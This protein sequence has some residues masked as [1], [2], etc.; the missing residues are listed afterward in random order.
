MSDGYRASTTGITVVDG[1]EVDIEV[2]GDE[3]KAEKVLM[4]LQ[5]RLGVVATAFDTETPPENIG[6]VPDE[7]RPMMTVAWTRLFD[8]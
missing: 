1:V 6:R 5:E 2:R 8:E 4:D 7:Y 3:D